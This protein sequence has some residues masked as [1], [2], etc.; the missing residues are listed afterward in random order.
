[1]QRQS[2]FI[3][4]RGLPRRRGEEQD[5][6]DRVK[7]KSTQHNRMVLI[8]EEMKCCYGTRNW[9]GGQ[10]TWTAISMLEVGSSVK[11]LPVSYHFQQTRGR[12]RGRRKGELIINATDTWQ[13]HVQGHGYSKYVQICEGFPPF[14]FFDDRHIFGCELKVRLK[15]LFGECTLFSPFRS[16]RNPE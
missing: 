6:W 11:S 15:N 12:T 10:D 13:R 9:S 4:I 7:E 14:F 3:Q 8:C 16:T 1:M 2:Y 5:N